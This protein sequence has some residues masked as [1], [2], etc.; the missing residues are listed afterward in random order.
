[1]TMAIVRYT[2]A[3]DVR[4]HVRHLCDM[5]WLEAMEM[6]LVERERQLSALMKSAGLE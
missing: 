5:A 6:R 4:E 2:D 3:R 1:M